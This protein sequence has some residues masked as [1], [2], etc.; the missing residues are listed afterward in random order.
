MTPLRRKTLPLTLKRI[1]ARCVVR[2]EC[3]VWQGGMSRA[4][5]PY[6]H[7]PLKYER[8]LA[9]GS[10]GSSRSGRIVVWRLKHGSEPE[11]RLMMTCGNKHCL[12]PAHM[13]LVSEGV[14]QRMF[15]AAGSYDSIPHQVARLANS[16][17]AAKLSMQIARELRADLGAMKH[18]EPGR[19]EAVIAAAA[20]LGVQ[21]SV[22]Y[23]VLRGRSWQETSAPNSSVWRMVA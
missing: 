1:Y 18:R 10:G 15:S 22:I 4:G 17:N 8:A 21:P 5:Y 2:G 12:N 6:I 23:G 9:Q 14:K 7:D 13:L 20:R 16:R 11:G 19:Q 3:R